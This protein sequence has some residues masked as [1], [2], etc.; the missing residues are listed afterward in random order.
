M[1]S[2]IEREEFRVDERIL[3]DLILILSSSP[4]IAYGMINEGMPVYAYKNSSTL[5]KKKN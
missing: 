1:E 5:K 4:G 3:W 2:M